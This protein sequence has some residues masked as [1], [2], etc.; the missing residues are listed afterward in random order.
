VL[1]RVQLAWPFPDV[2]TPMQPSDSL[3]PSAT[4]PVPLAAAS[5]DADA[6]SVPRE[7]DDTCARIRAVRRRRVTGSPLHRNSSR[8]GEGL[9]GYGTVLFVRALVEHPAGYG[10]LLALFTQGA[11]IAFDENPALSASGKTRGFG[12]AVPRPARS[13]AYASQNLFPRTAQ[14][15]LP[16]RAGSPLAGQDSH[17]LDDT[18]G[19]VVASHLPVPLDPQGLVAL[20]VLSSW[21]SPKVRTTLHWLALVGKWAMLDVFIV[22]LLVVVSRVRGLADVEVHYGLYVF[23]ASVIILNF[24]AFRLDALV[25]RLRIGETNGILAP[26]F[27]ECTPENTPEASSRPSPAAAARSRRRRLPQHAAAACCGGT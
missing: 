26:A 25:Q 20:N 16:A 23:A 2:I 12:A 10:P 11:L 3:P 17:L 27:P 18:R 4:P 22:A 1:G 7:A 5:L 24:T 15:W 13:H 19:F 21:A 14:G 8:R 9:P 6:C